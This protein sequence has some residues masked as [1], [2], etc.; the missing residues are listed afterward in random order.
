MF[1][2]FIYDLLSFPTKAQKKFPK[3]TYIER[4]FLLELRAGE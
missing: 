3:S 2:N 4:A 1:L